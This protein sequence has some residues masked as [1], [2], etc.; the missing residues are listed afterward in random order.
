[1]CNIVYLHG[2]FYIFS[3]LLALSGYFRQRFCPL[4]FAKSFDP[5]PPFR[6]VLPRSLMWSRLYILAM[7]L[8]SLLFKCFVVCYRVRWRNL[9]IRRGRRHR[10]WRECR[11][12][13][14]SNS[15][16]ALTAFFC[17]CTTIRISGNRVT[18]IISKVG[19]CACFILSSCTTKSTIYIS[20]NRCRIFSARYVHVWFRILPDRR[21]TILR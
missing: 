9:P 17:T 1:M 4:D 12:I 10:Q 19:S 20:D 6:L 18:V 15:Y 8:T 13:C 11:A 7:P 2:N 16:S 5:T 3:T 21:R 14:K